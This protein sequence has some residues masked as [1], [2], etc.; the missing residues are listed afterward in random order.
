MA[1]VAA[2]WAT[3]VCVEDPVRTG[4][5]LARRGSGATFAATAVATAVVVGCAAGG[6]VHVQV[7]VDQARVAA[8]EAA[9]GGDL[10]FG[11]GAALPGADCADPW[12]YEG[13]AANPIFAKFD[14]SRGLSCLSVLSHTDLVTCRFG[15]E[16]PVETVALLGD[17]H[18]ASLYEAMETVAEER[19]WAV[20]TYLKAGCPGLGSGRLPGI[21]Q[22][23]EER[24]ACEEWGQAALAEIA[25]DPTITRVFTSYRS[26]VYK[27]ED[28]DG[29]LHD[30]F[31]A[32]LVR[33]PMQ[34]LAD[35]GKRVTV[36]RAVPTTGGVH[37]GPRLLNLEASA[38]DC[39][40]RAGEVDDPCAGPRDERLTPDRLV[41]A[42][43]SL[44]DGRIQVVDLTD[45]FCDEQTCHELVGGVIVYFDGSHLTATFS[46]TLGRH[47]TAQL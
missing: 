40:A 31:P 45:A 42:A 27:Y 33:A 15:S 19:D 22:P 14:V 25:G 8:A 18:A 43:T 20:V 38:P 47:I 39:I 1:T 2:G 16:D 7:Q 9:A 17:S 4:T 11:A 21:G 13:D 10:C 35:A 24:P 12:A 5:P 26:D 34:Q 6:W 37:L 32:E 29:V 46:R 28:Q 23:A 44:Q 36:L 30:E 41:D 3:K